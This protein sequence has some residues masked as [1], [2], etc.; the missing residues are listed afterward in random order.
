M[1]HC[2][3]CEAHCKVGDLQTLLTQ[4]QAAGV[5]DVCPACEKW[6]TKLKGDMIR[7]IPERMQAAIT[8]R[9]GKPPK[10]WWSR[11]VPGWFGV[12]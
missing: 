11:L 1:A 5:V 2:D 7:E 9:K 4:Y 6:A 8:E 12:K 10:P 3:L